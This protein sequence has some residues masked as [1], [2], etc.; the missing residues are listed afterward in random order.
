VN[1]ISPETILTEQNRRRIP[2]AQQKS[3]AEMHPI[4]GLDTPEDVARAALYLASEEA[5]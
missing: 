1:C 2:E 4:R 5:V 3:L